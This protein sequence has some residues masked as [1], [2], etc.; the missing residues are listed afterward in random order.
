[1]KLA[2]F[3]KKGEIAAIDWE[4]SLFSKNIAGTVVRVE[5]ELRKGREN[6]NKLLSSVEMSKKI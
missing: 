5:M 3:S 4:H 6:P 2:H 1:M